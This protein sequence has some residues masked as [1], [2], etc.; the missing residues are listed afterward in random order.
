MKAYKAAHDYSYGGLGIGVKVG[1][2]GVTG[3]VGVT[4]DGLGIEG[5]DPTIALAPGVSYAI[6]GASTNVSVTSAITLEDPG[7][8]YDI[9]QYLVV[10]SAD[11]AV[12]PGV[13]IATDLGYGDRGCC[14]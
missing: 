1:G 5:G 14:Q 11:Y 3:V 13:S 6:P 10:V 9:A 12:L 2:A 7:D 4:I 8:G